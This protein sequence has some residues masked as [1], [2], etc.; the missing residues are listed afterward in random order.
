M[1]SN[2]P[3]LPR[4]DAQKNCADTSKS[5][6]ERPALR[7]LEAKQARANHQGQGLEGLHP[8]SS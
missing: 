8:S 1:S 5:A 2:D 6:W 3:G 7:R 4:G